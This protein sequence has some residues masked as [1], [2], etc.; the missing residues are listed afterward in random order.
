MA[1]NAW[2]GECLKDLAYY[3][4]HFERKGE[5]RATSKTTSSRPRSKIRPQTNSLPLGIVTSTARGRYLVQLSDSD[6]TLFCS[7]ARELRDF[8]IVPGDLVR[9]VVKGNVENESVRN[10]CR[11]QAVEERKNVFKRTA[12][13]QKVIEKTIAANLDQCLILMSTTEPEPLFDFVNR[14]LKASAYAKIKPILCWTKVDLASAPPITEADLP[15]LEDLQSLQVIDN[16][17]LSGL[18]QLL[19]NQTTVVVGLSGVGKSTLI[20]QLVPEAQRK[21]GIVSGNGDGKH[22]STSSQGFA[23]LGGWIID[24]PGIRSFGLGYLES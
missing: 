11:I 20:N 24:T 8:D 9:V 14:C 23:F 6:Q 7:R 10:L 5:K 1:K 15:D 3:E 4:D 12:D 21:T 22:T 19:A 13:D 16:L 2:T 17:D 18:D